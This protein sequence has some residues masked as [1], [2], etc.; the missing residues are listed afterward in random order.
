[1]NQPIPDNNHQNAPRLSGREKTAVDFGPLAVFFLAYFGGS[2]LV[3]IIGSFFGKEWSLAQGDRMY[4][5]LGMFMPAFAIAFIYSVWKEK[6]IAP[7]LLISG[8]IIGVMG[9]LTL[10]LKDKTFFYMKPTMVNF[11]FAGL[12]GGGLYKGKIFLKTL[13]DGAFVMP[14]PAWR[15]LTIRF[16]VFFV[17]MALINEGAWRFLT[18]DCN[19][20]SKEECAGE[21]TWVNLK[22]FGYTLLSMIFTALQV[23]Y[24]L[25]HST[26]NTQSGNK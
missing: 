21:A 1:M 3:P 18:Q 23:P 22:I 12:L 20:T 11:L 25:K 8:L 7:M 24:I 17:I 16:V 4:L 5:A 15:R 6:R 2:K 10:I 19:L 9:G 14:D 26:E 13:F